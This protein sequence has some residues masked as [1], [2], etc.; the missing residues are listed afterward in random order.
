MCHTGWAWSVFKPSYLCFLCCGALCFGALG[1]FLF[2]HGSH[3]SWRR[4]DL[5]ICEEKCTVRVGM[6]WTG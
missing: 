4:Q 2:D 6:R 5:D 3:G 1:P